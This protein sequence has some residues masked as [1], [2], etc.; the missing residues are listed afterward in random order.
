MINKDKI[1]QIGKTTG[2]INQVTS[3][4]VVEIKL[5]QLKANSSNFY[6]ELYQIEELANSIETS[7]QIEPIIVNKDYTIISGHRRFNALKILNAETALCII[8]DFKDKVDENIMLIS[9]N[10]QRKKSKEEIIKEVELLNTFYK[11]KKE[12][13]P[14]FKGNINKIIAEDLGVSEATVK[15]AKKEEKEKKEAMESLEKYE[16]TEPS[17]PKP[18]KPK[19]EKQIKKQVEKLANDLETADVTNYQEINELIMRI[20][21][22]LEA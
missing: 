10:K 5:N 9:A 8:R 4:L 3:E 12:T 11:L 1:A 2:K 13:D 22:L 17:I 14:N 20:D 18:K 7:G 6:D 21:S 16:K 19:T 15:R